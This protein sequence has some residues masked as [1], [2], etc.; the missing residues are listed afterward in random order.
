MNSSIGFAILISFVLVLSTLLVIHNLYPDPNNVSND[1]PFFNHKFDHPTA[2]LIGSSQVGSINMTYINNN[3]SGNSKNLVLYNL[4]MPGDSPFERKKTIDSIILLNPEIVFYGISL[5]DFNTHSDSTNF[6]PDVKKFTNEIFLRIDNELN[7][8]NPKV[9]TKR[10]LLNIFNST[11]LVDNKINISLEKTPFYKPGKN[12]FVLAS[13]D[14]I[15]A[16]TKNL[17]PIQRID[18][19]SF[20][21]ESFEQ[22]ISSLKDNEIE[23]VIYILPVHKNYYENF[24]DND[25]HNFYSILNYMSEKYDIKIYNFS[26]KYDELNAWQDF[27]HLAIHEKS[28]IYYDDILKMIILESEL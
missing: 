1:D 12:N 6:L 27:L 18:E 25:K 20:Q 8:I 22:I 2:F 3:I 13:K 16:L 23:V 21:R 4:A 26:A 17:S 5:R 10:A 28:N 14:E 7:W 19:Y 9:T 15:N 11:G 24:P